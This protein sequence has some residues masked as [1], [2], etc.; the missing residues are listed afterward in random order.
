MT[1]PEIVTEWLKARGYDGLAGDECGCKLDDL[2]PCGEPHLV[3]CVPGHRVKCSA[4][5]GEIHDEPY[6]GWH[7]EPGKAVKETDH[8]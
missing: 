4:A 3:D 6:D 5:C 7:M 2:M 1:I 8:D